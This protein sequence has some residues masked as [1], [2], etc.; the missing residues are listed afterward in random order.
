M[1]LGRARAIVLMVPGYIDYF[2]I[3]L[4]ERSNGIGEEVC[5]T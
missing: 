5:M 3:L 4:T 2:R 1:E